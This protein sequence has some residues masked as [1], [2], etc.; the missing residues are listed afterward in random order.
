MM[1]Q[2]R[3][4]ILNNTKIHTS[5]VFFPVFSTKKNPIPWQ[6][7][8]TLKYKTERVTNGY[9]KTE[10]LHKT[11]YGPTIKVCWDETNDKKAN[12]ILRLLSSSVY[13]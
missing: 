5:T 11:Y 7:T 9:D 3:L 4:S 8:E 1:N 12:M 10:G 6:G 2:I 13:C